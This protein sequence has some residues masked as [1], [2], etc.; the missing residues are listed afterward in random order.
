MLVSLFFRVDV[1]ARVILFN[2]E[3]EFAQTIPM[4]IKGICMRVL[5]GFELVE[6][7]NYYFEVLD[8]NI[9]V[10]LAINLDSHCIFES[11]IP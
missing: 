8:D 9:F 10:D 11:D 1:H 4:L 6:T 3:L 5:V 2:F 7:V